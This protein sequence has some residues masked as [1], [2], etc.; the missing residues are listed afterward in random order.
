MTSIAGEG[1]HRAVLRGRV[2]P[3]RLGARD[4]KEVLLRVKEQVRSDNVG[5]TAAGMA[6]Y[7]MLSIVPS[8]LAAV[9][10]YGL[11]SDPA[12]VQ[13]Q[14]GEVS[15]VV[16]G[17]ALNIV[18]DQLRELVS[19]S[20]NGLS[21][22]LVGS[23]LLALWSASKGAKSM[24]RGINIAYDE[25]ETRSSWRV[26]TLALAFTFGFILFGI[27][28]LSLIAFFPWMFEQ[29]PLGP[30]GKL[31]ATFVPWVLLLG[32]VVIALGVA[33]R[34]APAKRVPCRQCVWWGAGVAS[35]LWL[36]ASMGFSWYAG[37]F[38]S[39]N[40]TY[41]SLAGIVVLLFWLDISAFVILL[42]AELASEIEEQLGAAGR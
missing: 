14:I 6:F 1:E 23:V 5:I 37:S 16:P 35:V 28:S 36:A 3:R 27:V 32:A 39:F 12:E 2:R 34:Y 31:M 25:P 26:Q 19:S 17:D 10:I 30:F 42:G 4:W 7:F 13:Q 40:E 29:L 18:Q 38:G 8:L 9:S 20:E 15:E 24:I 22:G 11:V 33:Y 21:L 41:G